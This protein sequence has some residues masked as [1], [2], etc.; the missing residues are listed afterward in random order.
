M[1]DATGTVL[2]VV[3]WWPT[4][5]SAGIFI[6]E[7]VHATAR[8]NPVLVVFPELRKEI[9]WPRAEVVHTTEE[10]LPVLRIVVRTPLRRFGFDRW[11]MRR[12]LRKAIT[13]LHRKDPFRLM[14]VHV[15]TRETEE[16]LP[17]AQ[18]LR[19]PI[20]LTEHNTY[21]HRGIRAVREPEQTRQRRHLRNWLAEPII[22]VVMP[23][24]QSLAHT[25]NDEFGVPLVNM[26][27]VPNVASPE[28]GSSEPT[29]DGYFHI[30]A[31]A[32]WRPPKDHDTFIT[33]LG[34][35]PPVLRKR[36]I[37]HW[38]GGGPAI[39]RIQD[40]CKAEL[41]DM[42][43]RFLGALDKAGM[44]RT[45]GSAHLFVLPTTSEN[46]PCVVIESLCCG[47]PVV[48]MAV[49]GLPEMVDG[50]N[51]IL[52]PPSDP[53]ALAD[54]LATCIQGRANFDRRAIANA[55]AQRYSVEVVGRSIEAVY[56][57]A[58]GL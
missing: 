22:K 6:R 9:T 16:V 49:D 45:M 1:S 30:T 52:V 55:A 11:L 4:G 26:V 15:R 5:D 54:A 42:D 10:G 17:L 38:A 31:A 57:R 12:A 25:L 3:G 36:C 13:P 56:G 29:G 50:T 41:A 47:T 39:S 33:A 53:Q 2:N 46:L 7:H 23:V 20:V 24:S 14:H 8:H 34:L 18:E 58:I 21:Y 27:V 48:S 32:T 35:L 37:I 51:G 44:A 19:L 40:R 28:F 43:I